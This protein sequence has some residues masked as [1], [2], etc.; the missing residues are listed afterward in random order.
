[1]SLDLTAFDP[2]LKT[3]YS[4][5]RIYALA[6]I[7]NPFF[8]VLDKVPTA[9]GDYI[10]QP[11]D[12]ED[13]QGGSATL[14]T[15]ITNTGPSK[16]KGF[17]IY[18][19]KNYQVAVIDNE[20]I[21]ATKTN[22]NA[23]MPA[24]KE[25]DRAFRRAGRR[26]GIQVYRS[27][28]GAIGRIKSGT[29][30]SGYVITLDDAADAMNFQVGMELEFD[31]A[32]GGGTI[33]AGGSLTVSAVDIEAGTVTCDVVLTTS[34]GI[35]DTDYIFAAG[36]YDGCVQGLLDWV[37]ASAPDSTS[38]CGVDRTANI[39]RLGGLRRSCNG[40]PLLE[41]FIKMTATA[42]KHGASPDLA[43]INPEVLSNLL[44]ECEGKTTIERTQVKGSR[45]D[46]GYEAVAI[47]VGGHVVKL[48][49]DANCPSAYVW[50]LQKDTWTFYSAGPAP[51]FLQRDSLLMRGS[52]TD[53]YQVRVGG[54]ANLGCSA[55]GYNIIGVL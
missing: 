16:Y 42:A 31:A 55:P 41:S 14:A 11:L 47:T 30:L 46:L 25:I 5:K 18:R 40:E 27:G 38:F 26:Y 12:Y 22:E 35:A 23:F 6:D 21:E 8:G 1:M 49:P 17:K 53:D 54:Y 39:A 19:R 50:V 44:L 45:I 24:F 3:H 51:M 15:A 10:K 52:T 2:V 33:N 32:N 7:K 29:T 36:D 9:G 28:G 37:P 34:T 13:P 48:L 4:K 20:T 43:P